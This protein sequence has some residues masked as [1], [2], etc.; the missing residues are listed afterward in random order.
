MCYAPTATGIHI[1]VIV[2]VLVEREFKPNPFQVR[3]WKYTTVTPVWFW[4]EA[5]IVHFPVDLKTLKGSEHWTRTVLV[6]E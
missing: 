1:E 5:P 3:P 2:M 6:Y 4:M